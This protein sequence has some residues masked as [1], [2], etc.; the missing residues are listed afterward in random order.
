LIGDG[1]LPKL[2]RRGIRAHR[3]RSCKTEPNRREND[4]TSAP[5]LRGSIASIW[6]TFFH[7]RYHKIFSDKPTYKTQLRAG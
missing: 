2:G 3:K 6:R 4:Q 1:E 7:G 5:K